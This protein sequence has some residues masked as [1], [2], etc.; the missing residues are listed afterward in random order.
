MMNMEMD[1]LASRII[2]LSYSALN[3][4]SRFI[5]VIPA[6]TVAIFRNQKNKKKK[7]VVLHTF[8]CRRYG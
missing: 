8:G 4:E 7:M 1:D 2:D 5:Q 6:E 3:K